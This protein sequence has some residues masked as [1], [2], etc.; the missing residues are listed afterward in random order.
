MKVYV[1]TQEVSYGNG[2]L[3][4]C[5]VAVLSSY[6]KAV[7]AWRALQYEQSKRFKEESPEVPMTAY[8]GCDAERI[9]NTGVCRYRFR[10]WVVNMNALPVFPFG[11]NA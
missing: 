6:R 2:Y 3:N 5:V 7:S 8:E 11:D 1:I 4:T 9:Y 10:R